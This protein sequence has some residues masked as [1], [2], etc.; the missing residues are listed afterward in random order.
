MFKGLEG[1]SAIV[2]GGTT[3]APISV[4]PPV[5]MALLPSS[6]LNMTFALLG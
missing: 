6:P 4:E 2:T 5:T 3:P 1:K